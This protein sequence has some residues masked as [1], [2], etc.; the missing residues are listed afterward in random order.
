MGAGEDG[1]GSRLLG[2]D[3]GYDWSG[4][5]AKERKEA[6]L[7][8]GG[9]GEEGISIRE[10]IV[11]AAGEVLNRQSQYLHFPFESPFWALSFESN[12]S[13]VSGSKKHSYFTSLSAEAHKLWRLCSV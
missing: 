13:K 6:R 11:V 9:G 7:K 12:S 1:A 2:R 10:R 3:D 4:W 5:E 8:I